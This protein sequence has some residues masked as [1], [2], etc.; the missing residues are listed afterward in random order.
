MVLAHDAMPEVASVPLVATTTLWLYQ[1]F[2]SAVRAGVAVT[3]GGVASYLKL[4]E[5]WLLML[6]AR[7]VQVPLMLAL[8]DGWPL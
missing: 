3:V 4:I 2:E 1:P 7:S 8:A 5:P 6:P